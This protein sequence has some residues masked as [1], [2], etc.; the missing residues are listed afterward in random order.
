MGNA[1][2]CSR[3]CTKFLGKRTYPEKYP[4]ATAS[5][6][7]FSLRSV[8]KN[9]SISDWNLHV[10]LLPDSSIFRVTVRAT[11]I[12]KNAKCQLPTFLGNFFKWKI[13]NLQFLKYFWLRLEIRVASITYFS[14]TKWMHRILELLMRSSANLAECIVIEFA[15]EIIES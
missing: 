12:Y 8:T 10:S 9:F 3:D 1:K 5:T 14:Y 6:N 13:W 11:E 4:F 15:S 7:K 2:N